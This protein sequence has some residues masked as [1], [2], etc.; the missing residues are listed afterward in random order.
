MRSSAVEPQ[1]A[2]TVLL[3]LTP[4]TR[5]RVLSR[6]ATDGALTAIWEIPAGWAHEAPYTLAGGEALYVLEGEWMN[7]DHRYA[8][9]HYAYRA[10]GTSQGPVKSAC[11]ARLLMMWDAAPQLQAPGA[12]PIEP[13]PSLLWVDGN[14]VDEHPTPVAGPP[15][16]ITVRILRRDAASGGMTMI[17]NIPPGWEESRAEHHDCVEE[18]FKLSGDIWMVENHRPQVLRAGDYFFRPPRIK[19]GPMRTAGGTSSLIRF[20]ATVVNH[21]GPVEPAHGPDLR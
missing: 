16:G 3:G 13:Q 19:H 7:G 4:G 11:G 2:E 20:S 6:D 14:A 10:G 1:P 18:S 15:A 8:R 21:Y 12:V 9:G 5:L 17:V